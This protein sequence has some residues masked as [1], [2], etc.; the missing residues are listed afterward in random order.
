MNVME[1][2]HFRY[3]GNV[4]MKAGKAQYEESEPQEIVVKGVEF[5]VP[6]RVYMNVDGE[7]EYGTAH[8]DYANKRMF[9]EDARFNTDEVREK[10]FDFL[11]QATNLPENQ[12]QASDEIYE[13]VD[14]ARQEHD[15]VSNM[16]E[17]PDVE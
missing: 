7:D 6:V 11:F 17:G 4:S 3:E 8:L 9:F 12:H 16:K 10:V 1:E 5:F 2:K 15:E 13:Q 14:R